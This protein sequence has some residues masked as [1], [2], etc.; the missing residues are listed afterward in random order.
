MPV[1]KYYAAAASTTIKDNVKFVHSPISP[2]KVT[3]R[4]KDRRL[5][6]QTP[7]CDVLRTTNDVVKKKFAVAIANTV[8]RSLVRSAAAAGATQ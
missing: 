7:I 5:T 3:Y 4:T 2:V 1:E 6:L 8:H